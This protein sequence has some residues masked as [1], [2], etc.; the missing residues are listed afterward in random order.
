MV[1]IGHKGLPLSQGR[2]STIYQANA[3]FEARG[4]GHHMF[5][6]SC[7][8]L[9]G[10]ENLWSWK[11]K[12]GSRKNGPRRGRTGAL[13]SQCLGFVTSELHDPG[14]TTQSFWSLV[15]SSVF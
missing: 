4:Q 7:P 14:P 13:E 12:K 9:S 2:H 5:L 10:T 3:E 1:P 15:S 11:N 6:S 8:S